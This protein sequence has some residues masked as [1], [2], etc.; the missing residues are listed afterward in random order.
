MC[1]IFFQVNWS[2]AEVEI[3]SLSG[4]VMCGH[5]GSNGTVGGRR[6]LGFCE[7]RKVDGGFGELEFPFR[8]FHQFPPLMMAV[9]MQTPKY[10]P[11]Q[12]SL[13]TLRLKRQ[14]EK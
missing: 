4:L 10:G 6:V 9:W 2:I 7:G 13:V 12:D 3:P 5:P 1:M 11:P 8:P 14:K